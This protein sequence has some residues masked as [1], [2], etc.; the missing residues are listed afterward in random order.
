MRLEGKTVAITGAATGMGRALAVHLATQE[1]VAALV[2]C[3]VNDKDLQE[4]RA[5]CGKDVRVGTWLVDVSNKAQ[6]EQWRDDVVRD[7]DGC[8]VLFNNAGVNCNGTMVYGPN[9]DAAALERGWDRCFNIDFFGVLYCVRAFLPVL[10]S[11]KEAYIVNTSS[12][13]AYWTWPNHSACQFFPVRV[14]FQQK[15]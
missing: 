1:K 2:L 12:V 3:D 6:V 7:F 8:D 10:I 15:N 5:L 14:F 11:R 9:D 13:N 4:T